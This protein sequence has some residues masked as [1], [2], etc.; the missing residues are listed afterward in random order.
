M[1]EKFQNLYYGKKTGA[2]LDEIYEK[3]DLAVASL[4]L[5]KIKIEVGSFI[6]TGEYLAKGLPMITGSKVDV[7]DHNEF[8]YFLEYTND[9]TP[10]AIERMIEFRDRIYAD[11]RKKVKSDIREYA[12]KK[13]DISVSM[14]A[15]TD[16]MRRHMNE[17]R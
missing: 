4:G 3:V 10:I 11:G 6:K 14:Q 8:D 2:E 13:V 12:F 17:K 16:V 1:K 7:L 5:Y 15:V 9:S